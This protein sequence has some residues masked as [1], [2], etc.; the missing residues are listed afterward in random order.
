ME[1][2]DAMSSSGTRGGRGGKPRTG[3]VPRGG[4]AFAELVA[5]HGPALYA[6]AVWLTRDESAAADLLQDTFERALRHGPRNI[7]ST[8][9]VRWLMTVMTNRFRDDRRAQKVRRFIGDGDRVLQ[10]LAAA[11]EA[12]HP[13]WRTVGDDTIASCIE[14]LPK[15]MQDMLQLHFAGA[16]YAELSARF[17]IPMNTVGTRMLRIRQ[18]LGRHLR[19]ALAPGP[20]PAAA[21]AA[22]VTPTFGTKA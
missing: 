17:A 4:G 5:S 7:E 2:I 16:P 15:W 10:N 20:S 14:R 3:V 6:R 12:G 18:R 21:T 11:E 1:S 22:P 9:I 19:E 8:S 13:L